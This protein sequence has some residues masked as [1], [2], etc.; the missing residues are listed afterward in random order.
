[1]TRVACCAACSAWMP[2]PVPRS[3]AVATG[4]RTVMPGQGRGRAADAEDQLRAVR[5]PDAA[6]CRRRRRPRSPGRRRSTSPAPSGP[7]YGR[8]STLAAHLVA[9][10]H[11]P[12]V[13]QAVRRPA[14]RP[15]PRAQ[16]H[17]ALQQEQPHQ[18]LQ[19]AVAAGRPQRGHGLA[20][21]QRGVGGR[22]EQ[23]QQPVG[24]EGGGQQR[25]AQPGGAVVRSGSW[26]AAVGRCVLTPTIVGPAA[27]NRRR[28]GATPSRA[29]RRAVR[30]RCRPRAAARGRGRPAATTSRTAWA[31]GRRTRPGS[32]S[33]SGS[34]IALPTSP[35][36]RFLKAPRSALC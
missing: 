22:A 25:L 3:S 4:V 15:A 16:R 6:G 17:R 31:P 35:A 26:A 1:M 14:A 21:G 32:G 9:V 20:A 5:V 36:S 29:R 30:S 8:T 2:E 12:A 13:G 7:P 24:G 28:P 11:Q 23:F 18:R 27:D 10:L 33:P 34:A 19:R